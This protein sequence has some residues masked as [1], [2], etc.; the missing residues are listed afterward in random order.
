VPL[1]ERWKVSIQAM[2]YR[3]R[4]LDLIDGDQALNLYKQISFRRWRKKE[5]LDDPR[6]IPIEKPRLLKRAVELVLESGKRHPEDILNELALS[7]EWIEAFCALQPGTLGPK[8]FPSF[9]PT[10]KIADF[11]A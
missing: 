4:D 11:H 7:K 3:C 9:E 10:S 5:P 8:N 1:K 2:V 6:K